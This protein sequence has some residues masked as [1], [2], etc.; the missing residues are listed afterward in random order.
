LNVLLNA[1]AICKIETKGYK[2]ILIKILRTSGGAVKR[3][4]QTVFLADIGRPAISDLGQRPSGHFLGRADF[5]G[6]LHQQMQLQ[7]KYFH[8]PGFILQIGK[9]GFPAINR[10]E[11]RY[12]S[13]RAGPN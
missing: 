12:G 9:N 2:H 5:F 1:S 3:F 13:Q 6:R 10:Y 8:L 4:I 11:N 7:G